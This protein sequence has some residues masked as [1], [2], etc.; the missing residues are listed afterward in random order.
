MDTNKFVQKAKISE[1]SGFKPFMTDEEIV[2]IE[3][4]LLGFPTDKP[5]MIFEY[6]SG[7]STLYFSQLLKDKGYSFTWF[8][9]EHDL[10]WGQSVVR[11]TREANLHSTH[12]ILKEIP[13]YP[14]K[15]LNRPKY[16]E[17]WVKQGKVFDY[18][19]YTHVPSTMG[20]KFDFVL[21]DGRDRKNCIKTCLP[22]MAPEGV[23]ALHDADRPYYQCIFDNIIHES[24]GPRMKVIQKSKNSAL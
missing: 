22:L 12:I 4:I 24:P 18:S 23:I 11:Q 7:G 9:L 16:R 8:S 17:P 14:V 1:K 6:G 20:L 13:D 15:K 21:V 10:D 19:S 2:I 5:L 3:E